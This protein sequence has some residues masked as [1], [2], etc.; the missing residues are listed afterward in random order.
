[1]VDLSLLASCAV[2]MNTPQARAFATFATL[3]AFQTPTCA[4]Q[5][6]LACSTTTSSQVCGGTTEVTSLDHI[7]PSVDTFRSLTL[8]MSLC[9]PYAP[10]FGFAGVASSVSLKQPLSPRP[11]RP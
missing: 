10:F 7:T 8:T 5:L 11:T 6:S 4:V 3:R 2:S 1:M 9:P